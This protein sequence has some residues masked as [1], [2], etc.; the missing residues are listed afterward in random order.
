MSPRT[1]APAPRPRRSLQRPALLLAL[2]AALPARA[3]GTLDTWAPGATDVESSMG[4]SGLGHGRAAQ[5]LAGDLLLGYGVAERFSA[6]LGLALQANGYLADAEPGL[7]LGAFATVIDTALFD[8]D[9]GLELGACGPG[10]ARLHLLPAVELNLDL[11]TSLGRAGTYL[12]AGLRLS[13][14]GAGAEAATALQ[15]QLTPGLYWIP[16]DGHKLVVESGGLARFAGPEGPGRW[17]HAGATLGYNR[18]L[19]P[20]LELI[21]QVTLAPRADDGALAFGALVGFVATVGGAR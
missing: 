9:V 4:L 13:G 18:V 16:R 12:R 1:L 7:R 8:L 19:T 15:L 11:D 3:A 17:E 5:G 2:V 10:L 6:Y 14:A 21:T 20:Q